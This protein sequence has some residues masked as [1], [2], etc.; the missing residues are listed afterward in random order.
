VERRVGSRRR[1]KPQG[2][3]LCKFIYF[4]E[5]TSIMTLTKKLTWFF[6]KKKAKLLITFQKNMKMTCV[7]KLKDLFC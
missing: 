7:K 2:G 5:M 4:F 3:L 6:K 1:R